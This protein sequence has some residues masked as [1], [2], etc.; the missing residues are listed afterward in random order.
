MLTRIWQNVIKLIGGKRVH[1]SK[2]GSYQ[3]RTNAGV[4]NFNNNRPFFYEDKVKD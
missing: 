3:N 2:G 1:F 4:A